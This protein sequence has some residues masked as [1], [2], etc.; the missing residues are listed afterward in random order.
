MEEAS[1]KISV[2]RTKHHAIS[3]RQAHS[4][5][6]DR[7]IPFSRETRNQ[8][9]YTAKMALRSRSLSA[10]P[11]GRHIAAKVAA[12]SEFDRPQVALSIAGLSHDDAPCQLL[13]ADLAELCVDLNLNVKTSAQNCSGH[14]SGDG[15]YQLSC[16][17]EKLHLDISI[18]R[19]QPS[20][21]DLPLHHRLF[22]LLGIKPVV[23][24]T[25]RVNQ[26]TIVHVSGFGNRPCRCSDCRQRSYDG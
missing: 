18:R 9:Y 26:P 5:S 2:K 12:F 10:Q 3:E 15:Q 7:P 13:D 11:V 22:A 6:V 19:F 23:V 4:D 1:D 21:S 14:L 25:S 16:Q 17:G 24:E 8:R 20:G